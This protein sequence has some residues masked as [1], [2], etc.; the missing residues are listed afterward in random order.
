MLFLGIGGMLS[1]TGPEGSKSPVIF[2]MMHG[3]GL[4]IM[5]VAG[6]GQA[7]KL[8]YGWP[9]WLFLKIGCWVLIAALPTLAKKGMLARPVAMLLALALGGTAIWLAVCKPI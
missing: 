9:V 6:I 3:L 7:H 8:G 5:L 1:H 2:T 4:L